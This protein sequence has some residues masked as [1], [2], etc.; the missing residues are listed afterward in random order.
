MY[1]PLICIYHWHV[2]FL[3]YT[4]QYLVSFK[5]IIIMSAVQHTII[6]TSDLS[7][8]ALLA[9]CLFIGDLIQGNTA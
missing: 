4:Y 6:G 8:D 9:R 3:T 2:C 1:L 7:F 5:G